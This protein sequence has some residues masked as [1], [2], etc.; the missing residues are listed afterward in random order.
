MSDGTVY[1]K[2]SFRAGLGFIV[3]LF[4]LHF[5]KPEIDPSWNF[6]SEYQIGRF[7]WLMQLAF[8]FL[9]S[10]C[11]FMVIAL[12]KPFNIVGKIGLIMLLLSAIGM[13]IAA[14]FK[15]DPLNTAPELLTQSGKLHQLGA[16]LDQIPFA[17][18]LI[19]VALFRKKEWQ[20]NRLLQLILLLLVWF[21][22][23][24]FVGSI[25]AQFPSDGKFGP[26]VL[27]GWQNR[28]MILTQ[29]LWLSV[30]SIHIRSAILKTNSRL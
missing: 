25:K 13:V 21:G 10:S 18:V 30:M 28:I 11:L 22:F 23:I 26:S 20:V 17:V 12:W 15:T 14:I 9:A 2:W 24:Y 5:I 3:L 29:A 16:M 27:I 1:L 8:I 7:G 19:T 4:L 6:I